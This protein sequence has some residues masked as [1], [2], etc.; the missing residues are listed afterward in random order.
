MSSNKVTAAHLEKVNYI[1]RH[2]CDTA[3]RIIDSMNEGEKIS[4]SHLT[5]KV[6]HVTDISKSQVVPI[7]SMFVANYDKCTMQKGRLGGIYR[8]T[9]AKRQPACC[10]CCG[11][12]IKKSKNKSKA[13]SSPQQKTL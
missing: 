12:K 1:M 4:L 6:S 3:Q 13:E 8:G 7:V 11:Q 9:L 10:S 2:I 5:E